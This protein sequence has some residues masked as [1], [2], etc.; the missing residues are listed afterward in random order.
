MRLRDRWRLT[1]HVGRYLGSR[2]ARIAG[3]LLVLMAVSLLVRYLGKAA[4]LVAPLL[5]LLV[6]VTLFFW[7]RGRERKRARDEEVRRRGGR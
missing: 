2:I 4:I 5:V 7:M 1:V 6:G 3:F